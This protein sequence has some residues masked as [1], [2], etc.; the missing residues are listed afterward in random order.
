MDDL[1]PSELER[2]AEERVESW[3]AYFK[4]VF[5]YRRTFAEEKRRAERKDSKLVA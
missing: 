3:F 2:R 5:I 1:K 4:R